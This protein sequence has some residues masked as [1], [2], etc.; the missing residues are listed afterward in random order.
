MAGVQKLLKAQSNAALDLFDAS[1]DIG[2]GSGTTIRFKVSKFS[3]DIQ[4]PTIDGTEEQTSVLTAVY[5]QRFHTGRVEGTASFEGY[6]ISGVAAGFQN[7]P[8]EQVDVKLTLGKHFNDGKL[9]RI[10]FRMAVERAR[11]D[12]S[13]TEVGIP[14]LLA[15]RITDRYEGTGTN[16]IAE[17]VS[18]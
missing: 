2:T 14:L 11:I 8:S 17:T 7:L 5:Q 10:S 18:V 16:P 1:A 3:I 4:T 9:H 6:L 12:W 13:R 15:G